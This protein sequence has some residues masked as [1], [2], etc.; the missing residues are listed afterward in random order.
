LIQ[1][2]TA[3]VYEG[4]SLPRRLERGLAK[5]LERDGLTLTEA[6]GKDAARVAL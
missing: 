5:L 1:V 3:L 4:P 2:Y 6:T